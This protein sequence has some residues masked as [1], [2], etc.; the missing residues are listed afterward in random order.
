MQQEHNVSTIPQYSLAQ[1]LAIWAAAAVPMAM[2]G[3]VVAPA[4]ASG[5]STDRQAFTTRVMVLTLG[6]IWQ[7]VLAMIIVAAFLESY[8]ARRFRSVWIAIIV[9]SGQSVYFLFLLLGLVLGLA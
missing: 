7:F 4:L 8:P 3:W 1:I 5:A 6:L 2:L 9:H